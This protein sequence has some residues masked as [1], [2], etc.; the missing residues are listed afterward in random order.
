[1]RIVSRDL[2]DDFNELL[3]A[4]ISEVFIRSFNLH[5]RLYAM[6]MGNVKINIWG[7]NKRHD[8]FRDEK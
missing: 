6:F 8:H 1:M 3:I 7:F 2:N 4:F 5:V